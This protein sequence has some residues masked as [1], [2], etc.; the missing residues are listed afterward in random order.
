MRKGIIFLIILLAVLFIAGFFY[1]SRG[2]YFQAP[3]ASLASIKNL[4]VEPL[5]TANLEAKPPSEPIKEIKL[6]FLGDLMFD[7][8]IRQVAEK[9]GYDFVFG[10]TDKILAGNDLVIGNLEGPITDNKSISIASEFAAR[11]NYIFTFDPQVAGVLKKHNIN[12]ISLGNNHILNF[13]EE[14][15]M[16]TEKYLNGAEI[17]FFCDKNIR[18]TIYQIQDTKL[19][20]VCY[21]QF[22]TNAENKTLSDITKAKKQ[23]DIIILYAHWGKE[24]DSLI[25]RSIREIAHK[26][27]DNSVDLIIGS[28]PHVVQESE[29]YKDKKIYYSLGNFIFDQYFD[30]N[31]THGLALEVVI[32]PKDKNLDFQEYKLQLKNNGQTTLK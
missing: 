2:N 27:V 15:L 6:L 11:E 21:N 9:K 30:P 29:V 12:L 26:F 17:K 31:A 8:Y 3:P 23:A 16:Q 10:D 20:F 22:E 14:G 5:K 1:F 18:Y 25:L 13:G 4:E 24:Y 7:R 19:G 28:H 32:N